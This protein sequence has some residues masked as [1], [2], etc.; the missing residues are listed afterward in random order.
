MAEAAGVALA[1]PTLVEA[2]IKGG[3]NIY[4]RVEEARKIDE[5]LGRYRQL[6]LDLH[7]KDSILFVHLDA[8]RTAS[9]NSSIP[10]ALKDQLD[11]ALHRCKGSQ[12]IAIE[13]LNKYDP[14]RKRAIWTFGLW[15]S[16]N[17]RTKYERFKSDL[18]DLDGLCRNMNMVQ[19][20]SPHLLPPD[21][22]KLIHESHEGPPG[23][24][25]PLSDIWVA[26]G[27]YEEASGRHHGDFVLENKYSEVDITSLCEVLRRDSSPAGILPCLGYR[28]PLYNDSSPPYRS[29]LQLVMELQPNTDRQSL[30]HK[31]FTEVAPPLFN[32][33]S[34]AKVLVQ[35]VS[36]VHELG[37]VHKSIRSR[38]ILLVVGMEHDQSTQSSSLEQSPSPE[39]YLQDWTYV[40]RQI[41]ATSYNGTGDIWQRRIYEHPDRQCSPDHFPETDYLPKHDIYSLGVVLMEIF[42]WVPFVKP[43]DPNNFLASSR[44]ATIYEETALSFGEE[45][46]PQRYKGDDQK[47]TRFPNIVRDV[48]TKIAKTNVSGVNKELGQIVLKCLEGQ[49]DSARQVLEALENVET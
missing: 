10:R 34:V 24:L 28:Q 23:G 1:V 31:L 40:R 20:R 39:V 3:N 38:A 29:F 32:R 11:D 12:D 41:A 21:Y 35:A 26:S 37:L 48:W 9:R 45:V 19:Q 4:V 7:S 47:L 6:G 16:G 46:L 43:N 44:V 25:L 2:L 27:N 49:Y 30:A 42:L 17:L 15:G 13:E 33:L 8:L 5:I 18:E 22:F 36:N 14:E